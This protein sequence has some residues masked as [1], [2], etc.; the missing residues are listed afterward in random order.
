MEQVSYKKESDTLIICLSGKIDSGNSHKIENQVREIIEQEHPDRIILDFESLVYITSAGLRIML[1]LKQIINNT[2]VINVS[3]EVFEILD[4]T[5]FTILMDIS[6][7]YRKLSIDG[8]EVIGQGA[9]GKVYRIDRDTIVK[10]YRNPDSLPEIHR[11]RELARTAFVL[12]VPTAIPYDVVKIEG[13]GYGSVFELLNAVS[14]AKLLIS[15]E[16]SL[17]EIAEMSI[18]LLKII[19][20]TTVKPGSMPDMKVVALDWADFLKDYLPKDQYQKLHDLIAK[21]PVDYHMMHGDFHIKN[22]ML[23]N[24]ESLLIDMDTLCYGHPIFELA[25][26]YNAYVGYGETDH[27]NILEFL[28]IPFETAVRF[29]H[30]LLEQYLGTTDADEIKAVEEKARILGYARIMRRTIQRNGLHTEEGR[31]KIEN[32][33]QNLAELLARTDELTFPI[34]ERQ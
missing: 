27:D 19:H 1:R 4:M 17:E 30:K 22:V 14:F 9:N 6:K 13:G 33:R 31:K 16:K 34:M 21:L 26:M 10:V 28:G 20:S 25:A 32:C 12:G 18:D 8:C 5:G 2:S 29:W 15:E 24:G 7:A 11:E 23:Q 3:S